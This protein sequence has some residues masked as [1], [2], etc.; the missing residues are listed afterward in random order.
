MGSDVPHAEGLAEPMRFVD[1]LHGF[2]AGDLQL[3]MRDDARTLA[4]PGGGLG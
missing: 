4:S 3:V 2:S 1:D